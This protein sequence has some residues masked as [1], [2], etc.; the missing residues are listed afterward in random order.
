MFLKDDTPDNSLVF[1]FSC[2]VS[3]KRRP[4]FFLVSRAQAEGFFD[5]AAAPQ[6]ASQRQ[7]SVQ[8]SPWGWIQHLSL[9]S[10]PCPA[11]QQLL[12]DWQGEAFDVPAQGGAPQPRS[13]P[14][15][16]RCPAEPRRPRAMA[17]ATSNMASW[18]G[19]GLTPDHGQPRNWQTE[20]QSNLY[21]FN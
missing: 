8:G 11:R 18:I 20:N 2:D 15:V 3:Q 13:P 7:F 17:A 1:N 21:H 16:G 10:K 5:L 9:P 12:P 4:L 19:A 6:E 14:G